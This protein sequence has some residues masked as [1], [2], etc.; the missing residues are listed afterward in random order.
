MNTHLEET[1]AAASTAFRFVQRHL[2]AAVRTGPLI[3]T[4]IAGAGV[5]VGIGAGLL[6]APR[7]GSEFRASLLDR[8][9]GLGKAIGTRLEHVVHAADE[10]AEEVAAKP[11]K[12][13]ARR[14][15]STTAARASTKRSARV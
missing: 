15:S 5:V 12:A 2:P 11:T 3:F 4:V 14:S 8:S 6:F 13:T 10:A 1:L 7:S 9:Q